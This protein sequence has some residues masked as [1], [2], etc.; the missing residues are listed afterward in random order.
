[1]STLQLYLISGSVLLTLILVLTIYTIGV[2]LR[3]KEIRPTE[4][5]YPNVNTQSF[6]SVEVDRVLDIYERSNVRIPKDIIEEL[7]YMNF[8]NEMDIFNYIENQRHYWKLEN[9][10]KPYKKPTR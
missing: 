8:D 4:T 9:S 6:V 2:L 7:S 5:N 10:K 3:P 1:M